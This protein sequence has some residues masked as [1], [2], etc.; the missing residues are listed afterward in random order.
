MT[1][2]RNS[3]ISANV[4]R[5]VVSSDTFPPPLRTLHSDICSHT[6]TH[7]HTK[8]THTY[9][10]TPISLLT[11]TLRRETC[12][13]VWVSRASWRACRRRRRGHPAPLLAFRR[14]L[15]ASR[16]SRYTP[17]LATPSVPPA[18]PPPQGLIAST[19]RAPARFE[20]PPLRHLSRSP[21]PFFPA[22][23][24]Y[25]G[26]AADRNP[27]RRFGVFRPFFVSSPLCGYSVAHNVPLSPLSP[28]SPP[29]PFRA[30][31]ETRRLK[32]DVCANPND[33]IAC[34]TARC[35][36]ARFFL[37]RDDVS[38]GTHAALY[39]MFSS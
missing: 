2:T 1:V 13:H 38:T 35:V 9:I 37:K 33:L 29:P 10:H 6:Y 19:S 27:S 22:C 3:L 36:E 12:A 26:R 18:R 23:L 25:F 20:L 31:W 16:A 24:P 28:P 5:V 17:H 32:A 4:R 8:H 30:H 34:H 14:T 15:V 11:C 39:W 21:L 7:T